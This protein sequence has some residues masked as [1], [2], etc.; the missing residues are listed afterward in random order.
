M[1]V[2]DFSPGEI[3][4]AG[5]ADSI[6]LWKTAS[7][8]ATTGSV[9]SVENCF[10]A[11]FEAYR[12]VVSSGVHTSAAAIQFQLANGGTPVA[13]DYQYY[14]IS[15]TYATTTNYSQVGSAASTLWPVGVVSTTGSGFVYDI[16]NPFLT[17][18]TTIQG[19]RLD[20]RNGATA[21]GPFLGFQD[22][23]TSFSGLYITPNGGT[24]TDLKV[25]IYGYRL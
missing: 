1:P 4:T 19:A 6:G 2:P 24:Y 23:A 14:H 20:A 10:N 12:V 8:T 25:S 17:L 16:V 3:W 13:T 22:S 11:D 7:A 5:A 15:R 9:L 18:R 21:V